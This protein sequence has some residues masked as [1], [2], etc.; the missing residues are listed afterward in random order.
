M[1][2][3]QMRN[4]G[5]NRTNSGSI[6][7]SNELHEKLILKRLNKVYC[8]LGPSS[9]HGVGVFAIRDIPIGINPFKDSYMAQEGIMISK[10][11]IPP[12]YK[13]LLEAYHPSDKNNNDRFISN[14]PNE[15]MWTNYINYS[16]TPNIEL[17][18]NGEW[19]TLRYIQTN[20]ELVEDP[21]NLFNADGSHKIFTVNSSQYPRIVY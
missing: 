3:K 2:N 12:E 13:D 16:E 8:K 7:G 11:K 6:I 14:F 21:K 15:L 4:S 10:N 20:E 17:M 19:R 5:T 1:K 9:I 18:T